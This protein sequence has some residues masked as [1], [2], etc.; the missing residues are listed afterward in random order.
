MITRNVKKCKKNIKKC[1]KNVK[2]WFYFSHY[3]SG[4]QGNESKAAILTISLVYIKSV[5]QFLG[6]M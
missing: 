2:K 5:L 4:G 3:C 6:G 1:K